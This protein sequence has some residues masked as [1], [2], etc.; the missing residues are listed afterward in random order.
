M[1][2]KNLNA[3]GATIAKMYFLVKSAGTTRLGKKKKRVKTCTFPYNLFFLTFSFNLI[4]GKFHFIFYL[5]FL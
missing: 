5:T 3:I 2:H 1:I 4:L